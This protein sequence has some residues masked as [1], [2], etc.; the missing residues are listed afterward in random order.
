MGE[1]KG[2]RD[3]VGK[4]R[5]EVICPYQT[6]ER[7]AL[8]TTLSRTEVEVGIIDDMIFYL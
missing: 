5:Q 7:G 4:A 3:P 1:R 6:L 2:G 8:M